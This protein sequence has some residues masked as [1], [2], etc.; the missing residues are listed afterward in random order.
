VNENTGRHIKEIG[1]AM[2]GRVS[3]AALGALTLIAG[4]VIGPVASAQEQPAQSF[5]DGARW[6]LIV[7]P[8]TLHWHK[9]KE[10]RNVVLL[11]LE[12][13][14]PDGSLWGSALFRNSFGQASGYVYYGWVWDDLFGQPALYAKLTGG[15]LYGYRGKYK[16]KVPFNH[17]GFSPAV[18]P[19]IGWR[20]SPQDAVQVS[21][22]GTAGLTFS[23]NRRF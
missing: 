10:H 20:F 15:I 5:G 7:S 3:K 2:H 16:D 18:I 6:E 22:L 13:A 14:Q 19:A 9:D 12:R 4:F 11:G 23:Y 8:Y 21:A 17:G 1:I